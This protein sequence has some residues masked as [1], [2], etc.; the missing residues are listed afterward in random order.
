MITH[1][2]VCKEEFQVPAEAAQRSVLLVCP[3]CG[4]IGLWSDGDYAIPTYQEE[5]SLERIEGQ[6]ATEL[7]AEPASGEETL[8]E[9]HQPDLP[10]PYKRRLFLKVLTGGRKG[11]MIPFDQG[12]LVLGRKEA[13][14]SLEDPKISRKHA[15]VEA[16][17]RENIFLRD[18][19]S[20]NGSYLNGVRVRSKKLRSGDVIR[21]GNTEMQFL[22]QDEA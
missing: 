14:V 20:T 5:Q 12:R 17:S 4:F 6:P 9:E 2:L 15:M 11:E 16:I 19:A 21:V 22:W 7:A 1:C 8:V 10:L 3:H 13:D 18:L